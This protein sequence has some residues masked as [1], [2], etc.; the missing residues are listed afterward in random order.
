[1]TEYYLTVR[2]AIV[3]LHPVSISPSGFRVL[4][5]PLKLLGNAL[6]GFPD[7]KDVKLREFGKVYI[8]GAATHE[9][10]N[11]RR[12]A[13]HALQTNRNDRGSIEIT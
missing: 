11:Q 13:F 5:R 4:R 7:S 8:A 3:V 10:Q 6:V 2:K 12:I 1:M 9:F